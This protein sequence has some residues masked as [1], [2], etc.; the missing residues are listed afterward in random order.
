MRSCC[1]GGGAYLAGRSIPCSAFLAGGIGCDDD[2]DAD[3]VRGFASSCSGG[4]VGAVLTG[5][6]TFCC[7]NSWTDGITG[8]VGSG[9]GLLV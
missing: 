5:V 7:I 8:G 3:D 6:A 2:C 1:G 9:N 4:T